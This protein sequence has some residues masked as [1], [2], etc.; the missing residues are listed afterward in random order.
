MTASGGREHLLDAGAPVSINATLSR[1]N[2]PYFL[3]LVDLAA[4]LKVPRLGFSRLVP[5]GRGAG[6]LEQM[7]TLAEVKEMYEKIFSLKIDGLKITSGDPVA[8]QMAGPAGGEDGGDIAAG[9]CA[10]GISGLTL[11][12]DGG[13]TPCRRLPLVIGNVRRQSLRELWAVSPVLQDLRDRSRYQGR[14]GECHRWA[15]CRGC[16]A[17]AYAWS[18]SQGRPN[19]LAPDPQCFL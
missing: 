15:R 11:L 13:V 2:A 4:S 6:M 10:A 7:L 9:G 1:A 14:C 16:R 12:P 3:D 18:Q 19:Y 8:S 17:I 5:S